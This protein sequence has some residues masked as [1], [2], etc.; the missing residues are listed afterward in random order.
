MEKAKGEFCTADSTLNTYRETS[1][2]KINKRTISHNDSKT[3]EK[4]ELL[5]IVQNWR[6]T[7][8]LKLLFGTP[9]SLFS[10]LP[11]CISSKREL[12][13]VTT[14]PGILH[15]VQMFYNSPSQLRS[16]ILNHARISTNNIYSI[17]RDALFSTFF[18]NYVFASKVQLILRVF[19]EAKSLFGSKLGGY[20]MTK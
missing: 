14:V 6:Y 16:R 1:K 19:P 10:V 20:D 7:I 13:I 18:K 9:C 12:W 15:T 3:H 2:G 4:L 8:H 5:A 17:F 11:L